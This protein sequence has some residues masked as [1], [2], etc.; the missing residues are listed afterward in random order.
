MY[1]LE[2]QRANTRVSQ[3]VTG[4]V[5]LMSES[6]KSTGREYL[7]RLRQFEEYTTTVHKFTLDDLLLTKK[8]Q[9]D[10]Y[11]L[12]RGY[13]TFLLSKNSYSNRTIKQRV[14]TARDLLEY[15]DIDT[16]RFKYKV[17]IPKIVK[18]EI[19]ALDRNLII[20]ILENCP[21]PRLKLYVLLL[22]STGMRAGEACSIRIMDLDLDKRKVHIRGEYTK[23]KTARYVYL[24][25]ELCKSLLIWF[26]YKYRP[27][28]KYFEWD[29]DKKYYVRLRDPPI[30]EP[31]RDETDLI[32]GLRF[33][34]GE[35]QSVRALYHHLLDHFDKV[36]DRLGIEFEDISKRRRKIT[37]HSFRR[38]VKS[39]I[40][41]LGYSDYSEWFI[42]HAHSTYY[43]R[44]E[45]EKFE[46]FKKLESSL[47]YLDQAGLEKKHQDVISRLETVE[48]EN[49]NLH[50]EVSKYESLQK[51]IE[52]LNRKMGLG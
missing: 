52:E 12:L 50:K 34:T 23:T 3:S 31:Q 25:N 10:V 40:S 11:E 4:Y 48:E 22:A 19:E 15:N 45:K 30:V 24:T 13:V 2:Q 42:G 46:L 14:V 39:T 27:R 33:G 6:S 5:K 18:R 7:S 16:G 8:V 36:L 20:D 44:P 43:R 38:H 51:Q 9:M 35:R 17:K 29:N 21:N 28:K 41:D 37:L 32:F 49:I 47:T 1:K 26:D